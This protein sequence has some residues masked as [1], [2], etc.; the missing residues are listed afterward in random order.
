MTLL[1]NKWGQSKNLWFPP[2]P[3]PLSNI[4]RLRPWQGAASSSRHS[5][6]PAQAGNNVRLR[7]TA[8]P[9]PRGNFA[10]QYWCSS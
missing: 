6:S 2:Y 1:I 8:R 5:W 7:Q 10:F 9:E 3:P 4:N